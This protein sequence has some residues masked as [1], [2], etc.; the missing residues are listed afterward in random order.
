MLSVEE[1]KQRIED[2][3]SGPYRSLS[4]AKKTIYNKNLKERVEQAQKKI[5]EAKSISAIATGIEQLMK[6]STPAENKDGYRMLEGA[7]R[8]AEEFIKEIGLQIK[9]PIDKTKRSIL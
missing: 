9:I 4:S 1:A 2:G 7:K 8:D 5:Y 3:L 6:I